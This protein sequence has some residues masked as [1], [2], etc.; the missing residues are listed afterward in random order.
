MK[1]LITTLLLL[2]TLSERVQ[3]YTEVRSDGSI[4]PVTSEVFYQR[5]GSGVE[6]AN[7]GLGEQGVVFD[8]TFILDTTVSKYYEVTDNSSDPIVGYMKSST[9]GGAG[10]YSASQ[11]SVYNQLAEG[12][13]KSS[14]NTACGFNA[15]N[16][17]AGTAYLTSDNGYIYNITYYPG[18]FAW[19]EGKLDYTKYDPLNSVEY[20]SGADFKSAIQS[21]AM[22]ALT[23]DNGETF[24]YNTI[25]SIAI[26]TSGTETSWYTGI[27]EQS[28]K[29]SS[30]GNFIYLG[31]Y[32]KYDDYTN[33]DSP[34]TTTA[35]YVYG[36]EASESAYETAS[37]NL[38]YNIYAADGSDA[39]SGSVTL[40]I[41]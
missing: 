35:V 41:S 37:N 10:V 20:S 24:D 19:D 16:L 28:S 8:G 31:S 9:N 38:N 18:D 3:S 7:D 36:L 14:F 34:A 39:L 15:V 17:L 4:R 21:A 13:S 27:S 40:D 33:P 29:L 26:S 1:K 6:I 12:T 2:T 32:M 5:K 23:N 11:S 22:I 25:Q 30:T